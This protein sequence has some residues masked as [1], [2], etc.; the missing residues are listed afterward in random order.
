MKKPEVNYT[1]SSGSAALVAF[2][3]VRWAFHL[4]KER[5]YLPYRAWGIALS[6]GMV[7]GFGLAALLVD[8]VLACI[9][10]PK[11]FRSAVWFG[12]LLGPYAGLVADH[13]CRE[14]N[15]LF[16]SWLCLG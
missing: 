3:A 11:R 12:A 9:D 15:R 2:S 16:W 10:V 6:L 4:V 1:T 5:G 14:Y 7:L 13:W 8:Y